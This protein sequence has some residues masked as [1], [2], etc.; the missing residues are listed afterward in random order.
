MKTRLPG[1]VNSYIYYVYMLFSFLSDILATQRKSQ[2]ES[3]QE[4]SNGANPLY[5]AH[6]QDWLLCC[7]EALLAVACKR[8]QLGKTSKLSPEHQNE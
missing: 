2:S 5:L 1:E 4:I 7:R 6:K 8:K 3:H